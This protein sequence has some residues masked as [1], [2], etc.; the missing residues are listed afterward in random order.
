M[1]I[2]LAILSLVVCS[3]ALAVEPV[4]VVGRGHTMDEARRDAYLQAVERVSGTTVFNQRKRK[5]DF[6]TTN[7]SAFYSSGFQKKYKVIN[8]DVVN[9]EYYITMDIWVDSDHLNDGILGQSETSQYIDDNINQE[10][11]DTYLEARRNGDILLTNVLQ[12]FPYNAFQIIQGRAQVH[13]VN[14]TQVVMS[15][16]YSM[17]W[18][19]KFLNAF[20]QAFSMLAENNRIQWKRLPDGRFVVQPEG[21]ICIITNQRAYPICEKRFSYNDNLRV[22]LIKQHIG[23]SN[24]PMIRVT[25]F[26]EMDNGTAEFCVSPPWINRRPSFY[27][28]GYMTPIRLFYGDYVSSEVR[29]NVYNVNQIKRVDMS[30]I[31]KSE[32]KSFL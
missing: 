28:F 30:V 6:Q 29:I 9:G 20:Q 11:I 7:D 24:Q 14:G 31:K 32:C 25:L 16:P 3:T 12:D 15:I 21:E 17:M 19:E 2:L 18:N 10:Q 23:N 13:V 1:K 22:E 27:S 4:R 26:D 8:T 5:N